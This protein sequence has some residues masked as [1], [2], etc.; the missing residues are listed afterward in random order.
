MD[1]SLSI[2]PHHSPVD[3]PY[4]FWLIYLWNRY[5][6]DSSPLVGLSHGVLPGV[7]GSFL[8]SIF[9]YLPCKVSTNRSKFYYSQH[10]L[11]GYDSECE[12]ISFVCMIHPTNYLRCHVARCTT[13]LISIIFSD[14]S[15]NSK[16]CDVHVAVLLKNYVFG[17]EIS[18]DDPMRMDVLKCQNNTSNYKFWMWGRSTCFLLVEV[19]IEAHVIA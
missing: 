8:L 9:Y 10:D 12:K 3:S 16:I 6:L 7:P 5:K 18:M 4:F 13:G 11:I 19:L 1:G 17:L 2:L 14:F 15:G